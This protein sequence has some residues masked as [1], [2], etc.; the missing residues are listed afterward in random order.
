M[1]L[2]YPLQEVAKL[3]CRS[4]EWAK[5]DDSCKINL[6][7]I[8]NADYQ[9][10]AGNK[11]YTDI[12][13]V[14]FGGNYLSG[15]AID[16]GSHYG[17]DIASAKGTPLYSIANGKVY[18]AGPQAGYGNVV[19]IQFIYNGV[20]YFATYGHMDTISVQKGQPVSIGQK[21]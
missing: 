1:K 2:V 10:Y 21:I 8:Q 16:Q 15:W 20:L 13:T 6:P 5:L 17:V 7:L 19:K 18:Y 9:K 12:Y 3:E 4:E 11:L 14:L